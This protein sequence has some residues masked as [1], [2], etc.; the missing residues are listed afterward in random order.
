VTYEDY[1]VVFKQKIDPLLEPI[2]LK[3][4][5]HL[6]LYPDPRDFYLKFR[7]NARDYYTILGKLYIYDLIFG[8]TW[9][10]YQ[11]NI[12]KMEVIERGL[13]PQSK[14]FN[15]IKD[16]ILN[17]DGRFA[18]ENI[19]RNY[20]PPEE[21]FGNFVP[22][23]QRLLKS[24]IICSHKKNELS[25]ERKKVKKKIFRRGYN[26]KGTL[27]PSVKWLP[28]VGTSEVK[29][30]SKLIFI[31][32]FSPYSDEWIDEDL[33]SEWIQE[34]EDTG[35]RKIL[36][37]RQRERRRQK[38]REYRERRAKKKKLLKTIT[39]LLREIAIKSQET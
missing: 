27:R 12:F 16:I 22:I 5:E 10:K 39:Y 30:S 36:T 29:H 28:K 13:D 34:L 8:G 1:L 38:N 32:N 9:N 17:K 18:T 15:P 24:I 19:I 33:Y 14:Y 20:L 2:Q 7:S 26:D 11:Q 4:A 31:D 23:I 37:H 35:S 3:I 6:S 25:L 21:I